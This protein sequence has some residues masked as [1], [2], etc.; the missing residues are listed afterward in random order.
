MSI[1]DTMMIELFRLKKRREEL[2]QALKDL[3]EGTIGFQKN[4]KGTKWVIYNESPGYVYLAKKKKDLAQKLAFK[5]HITNQIDNIE[6]QIQLIEEFLLKYSETPSSYAEFSAEDPKIQELIAPYF[7]TALDEYARWHY[8]NYN[9]NPEHADQI[10]IPTKAGIKVR[11]KSEAMIAN[12]LFD[13]RIP[14]H[15]EELLEIG[16]ARYYPDFQIR[17][18][19]NPEHNIIW[20]HFGMLDNP[21]YLQNMKL[22]LGAY[23]DAGY[24]M[25]K[26][27]IATFETK[28]WPLDINYVQ[29][30][31]SYFFG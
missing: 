20:E 16:D 27:L 12:C 17:N 30:L 28:S 3:P 1:K 13:N 11:S 19:Q 25:N 5:K 22:K 31:I 8:T 26:D 6:N 29:M 24:V 4:G 10:V 14:F 21:R 2:L 9:K 15:Y 23:F 18:P 7:K